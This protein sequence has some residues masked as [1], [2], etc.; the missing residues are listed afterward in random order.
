MIG[1]SQK[2]LPIGIENF[3]EMRKN[4]YY[5]VDKTAMI[6]D[7]LLRG[8]KVNLF[9]RPRRF[10]KSL[11][12][13]MLKT[14]FSYGADK[15]IFEGL[16]ISG[17]EELCRQHMGKYP[18]ISI[19][20][21]GVS[22]LNYEMARSLMCSEI[23]NEAMR[24]QFLLES[25][26]LTDLEKHQYSQL[27]TLD[28]SGR[29]QFA[30]SD[31][32]L[33]ESLKTLSILLEKYYGQK[34]VLLIDEYDVPLAKAEAQGYY[35]QMIILIRN[36]FEKALKTNDS[37]ELAVLT[38]CLRVSKE[39][40]FT[41]LNNL[42]VF[43]VPSVRFDEYFGFT[44]QEVR[45]ML[46]YYGLSGRYEDIRDW[47]DGYRLGNVNVYCPWAVIN[48][49]DD[50]L[51]EP[52]APLRNYWSNTS[53]NDVI[54][55]LIERMG[56]GVTKGEIESLV[57]GETV[58]K[59]IH[60]DL[61]Y[62]Q[63]Y[64]SIDNLWSLL[65]ATGYLT[66]RGKPEGKRYQLAIPNME[67]RETFGG[68]IM[69]MFKEETAKDPEMLT[70][71]CTALKTGNEQ[72]AQRLFT[73]YLE[74]S[75]SLRDT[76]VRKSLKENFYHGILLGILGLKNGWYVKSN[77]ET[78]DGYGDIVIHV[79]DE[80]IGIVIEVKYAQDGRLEEACKE[81]LRQIEK[82]GYGKELIQDKDCHTLFRYGI[83]CYKKQ[84]RVMIEK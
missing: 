79:E 4:G 23:G 52:A 26:R 65:L 8:G 49:C 62:K 17:E 43:S 34:A 14:F 11:N 46:A 3:T 19:S 54:R 76:F 48:F 42:K 38:G 60:E 70:A 55:R 29:D 73:A 80:G 20:L 36:L 77:Y 84:C 41:G 66:Y 25:D 69:A 72:E 13:S 58:T 35:D 45:D 40:I 51:D 28:M 18:V 78:G 31:A 67:I 32:A 75:I 59:E 68:Q 56:N 53:G 30:M 5:Y 74:K 10:G 39:S 33:T 24:F 37:L 16:K 6:R 21:K 64:D 9:T 44:D 47:Y 7:L 22:G 57:A 15:K 82:R 2:R 1:Q 27:V 61:T 12:M 63:V 83:G 81:A 50:L 71:F